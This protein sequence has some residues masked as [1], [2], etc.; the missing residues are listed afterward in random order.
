MIGLSLAGGLLTPVFAGN[1]QQQVG[2]Q[3]RA[4]AEPGYGTN[5]PDPQ[6]I[7]AQIIKIVL[8]TLGTVFLVLIVLSG[9]WLLTAR[10]QE[11]KI[12]KAQKTIRS[13]V[14]GLMIVLMAYSITYF[15]TK[16]LLDA[17]KDELSPRIQ[18]ALE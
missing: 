15:V 4:G 10:G 14:V 3:L 8:S 13:A 9:Y 6:S 1:L 18:R 5:A 12:E 7:I 17:Q 2:E 11:E 16:K